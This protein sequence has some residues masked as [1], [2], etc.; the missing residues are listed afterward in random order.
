MNTILPPPPVLPYDVPPVGSY[1]I[2]GQRSFDHLGEGLRIKIK[3]ISPPLK[4]RVA[5]QNI[6]LS[7]LANRPVD[8][9]LARG[10]LKY[11]PFDEHSMAAKCLDFAN[12]RIGLRGPFAIVDGDIGASPCQFEGTTTANTPVRHLSPKLSCQ[13]VSWRYP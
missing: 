3:E 12:H 2:P 13:E 6:K 7:K 9:A 4:G 11:I 10:A 5:D 8:D 1:E